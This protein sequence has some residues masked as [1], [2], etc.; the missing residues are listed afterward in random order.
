MRR[1]LGNV[2]FDV[3]VVRQGDTSMRLI[4]SCYFHSPQEQKDI[5]LTREESL[6]RTASF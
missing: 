5:R 2:R 4:C 1:Q 6:K 3:T